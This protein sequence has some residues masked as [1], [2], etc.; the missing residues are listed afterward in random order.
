LPRA[1]ASSNGPSF[2]ALVESVTTDLRPRAVLDEWLS[3]GIV[4]MDA[5]GMVRLNMSAF[6]PRGGSAEQL[7]YFARN[8]HDHI[9][10]AVANV[11]S[12]GSP[13]FVDRSVHY[14]E[15]DEATAQNLEQLARDASRRALLEV[16]RA[17]IALVEAMSDGSPANS[18]RVRLNFGTYIYRE[19]GSEDGPPSA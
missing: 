12:A 8:L 11:S 6:I 3:Q 18:P 17:A 4:T 15:L 1:T 13:P 16:N 2:D 5:A 7:F 9:A 10:A 14:D 19:E